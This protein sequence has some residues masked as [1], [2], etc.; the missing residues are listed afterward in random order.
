[1]RKLIAITI[2]TLLLTGSSTLALAAR[3]TSS[4][5]ASSS[6][7]GKIEF[8]EGLKGKTLV[9]PTTKIAKNKYVAW[10]AHFSKKAG[11]T[12]V[13]VKLIQ[14]SGPG[15]HP[16]TRWSTSVKVSKKATNAKE[17]LSP[18]QLNGKHV[19][20]GAKFEVEYLAGSHKLSSGEFTRLNCNN[21]GGTG[22]GY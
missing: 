8:G 13:S 2:T 7:A 12:K 1:M 5:P 14:V 21:C 6:V 16:A 22:G 15:T 4:R 17:M 3:D 19:T 9:H 11:T 18:S 10:I 20:A